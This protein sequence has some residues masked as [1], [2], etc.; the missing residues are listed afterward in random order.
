[1]SPGSLNPQCASRLEPAKQPVSAGAHTVDRQD[2]LHVP[3]G[4]TDWQ[5]QIAGKVNTLPTGSSP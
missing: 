3:A 4:L 2:Q 1:M 5:R